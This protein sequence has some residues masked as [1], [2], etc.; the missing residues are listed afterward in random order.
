MQGLPSVMGGQHRCCV[1]GSRGVVL[2]NWSYISMK[3]IQVPLSFRSGVISI[4]FGLKNPTRVTEG[5]R[6]SDIL[7][8]DSWASS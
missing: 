6:L 5:V 4:T 1:L 8:L 2:F 7:E 3:A